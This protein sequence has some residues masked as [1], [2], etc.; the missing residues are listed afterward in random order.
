M[1]SQRSLLRSLEAG[2]AG[3][4]HYCKGNKRHSILKGDRI[5][6]IKIDRDDFHY[7]L[8]CGLKFIDTARKNLSALEAELRVAP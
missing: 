5:L 1:G 2:I 8:H 4:K 3:R 7:C 6:V